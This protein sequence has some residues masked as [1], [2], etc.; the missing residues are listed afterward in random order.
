MFGF[1]GK[2]LE[3]KADRRRPATFKRRHLLKQGK[4]QEQ[5]ISFA[6]PD[7]SDT[8]NHRSTR[9]Y[10]HVLVWHE[11]PGRGVHLFRHSQWNNGHD[12]VCHRYI[13]ASGEIGSTPT[14]PSRIDHCPTMKLGFTFN[15]STYS[16][17]TLCSPNR[18]GTMITRGF[19]ELLDSF[20][21]EWSFGELWY[22][23]PN[24]NRRGLGEGNEHG[25]YGCRSESECYPWLHE[26]WFASRIH[27]T[28]YVCS[29]EAQINDQTSNV[30]L[31]RHPTEGLERSYL[32]RTIVQ[33][34]SLR[35]CPFALNEGRNNKS[36]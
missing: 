4:D 21:I 1:T 6:V 20:P 15:C 5:R 19:Q 33:Y 25:S 17:L 23:L 27:S 16:T 14:D 12:S 18:N 31:Y 10:R 29:D 30:R 36:N 34:F 3:W 13:R 7:H 9:L 2:C 26:H 22:N 24:E 35:N 28:Q 8:R 32:G 11:D